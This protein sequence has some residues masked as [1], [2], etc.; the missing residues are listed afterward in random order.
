MAAS[1]ESR[2]PFLD[3]PF[4]EFAV[5]VPDRLK[6]HGRT[7][8]H[9]LKEAVGDLL[10]DTI[11]HRKK[12]GFP[13]PLRAWL[14]SEQAAPLLD[15]ARDRDGVM[16]S[17]LDMGKV[18]ELIERHRSGFHDG[19]EQIWRLLNLQLWGEVCVRGRRD[20]T[21]ARL[22]RAQMAHA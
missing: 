4:V 8:K 12:M 11:V 6:L 13:T 2:V 19:T 1:I 20:E 3:H 15:I 21:E 16:A 18:D 9:I 7:G 10:P 22:A 5:R 14:M 17:Y